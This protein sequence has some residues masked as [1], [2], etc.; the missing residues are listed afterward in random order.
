MYNFEEDPFGA[1]YKRPTE[2]TLGEDFQYWWNLAKYRKQDIEAR[3]YS[4]EEIR[5][6]HGGPCDWPGSKEDGVTYW[7]ELW[8]GK[9]VGYAEVE[10]GK[11]TFPIADMPT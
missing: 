9:A 5:N 2:K 8:N 10:R 7:V 11:A 4:G 6:R 1:N 3:Q